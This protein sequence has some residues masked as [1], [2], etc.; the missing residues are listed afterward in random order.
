MKFSPIIESV[1]QVYIRYLIIRYM[2]L[3]ANNKVNIKT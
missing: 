3:Y 1:S 2:W